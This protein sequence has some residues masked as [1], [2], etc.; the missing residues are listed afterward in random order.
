MHLV[1]SFMTI[2][3]Q[4]DFIHATTMQILQ[5]VIRYDLDDNLTIFQINLK[6]NGNSLGKPMRDFNG[7]CTHPSN[8]SYVYVNFIIIIVEF[9][10][11]TGLHKYVDSDQFIVTNWKYLTKKRACVRQNWD[12]SN[13][14]CILI[15]RPS[16]IM[17]EKDPFFLMIGWVNLANSTT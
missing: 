15:L 9:M 12:G 5:W 10:Y 11:R 7:R 17:L 2:L 16:C 8:C 3:L 6:Y 13:K 4:H 1:N 14:I